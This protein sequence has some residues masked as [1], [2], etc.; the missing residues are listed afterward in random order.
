LAVAGHDAAMASLI[1]FWLWTWFCCGRFAQQMPMRIISLG[2]GGVRHRYPFSS[3]PSHSH[4][5]G[6]NAVVMEDATKSW[7]RG[8]SRTYCPERIFA[9]LVPPATVPESLHNKKMC[10]S[11]GLHWPAKQAE[12]VF[13]SIPI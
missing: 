11:C 7:Y 3:S 9:F 5:M 1:I 8:V 12:R 10:A 2:G 4:N 13:Q 6:A